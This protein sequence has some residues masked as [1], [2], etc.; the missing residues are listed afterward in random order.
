M[1]NPV[2][3]HQAGFTLVEMMVSLLAGLIVVGAVLAFALS[4]VRANSEYLSATRLSQ[5]L[6]ATLDQV[7][8]DLRRAGYDEAALAYV[9]RPAGSTLASPF[10]RIFTDTIATPTTPASCVLY[11]YDRTGGTPGVL[12]LGNGEA[13]GIRRVDRT[14]NGATVGVIE[15]GES[16]GTALSC[17][18]GSPDYTSQPFAC[19]NGWCPL[20]DPTVVDVQSF[21]I[22][23]DRPVAGG[24]PGLIVNASA[25]TSVL[26][27]Q[28][29]KFRL[30]ITGQ[31][32]G[33]A[34]VSRSLR[35]DVRVRADCVRAGAAVDCIA[36][37]DGT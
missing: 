15:I 27:M 23:N 7:A 28:V 10:A 18:D 25:T 12:D 30:N 4:S 14:I 2:V 21:T 36:V 3:R 31:R 6:R 22:A 16:A 29:R 35:T 17:N 9:S 32:V 37:P 26:P 13:R 19:R 20:S 1:N 11:A 33:D 24:V 8:E 5:D 34:S